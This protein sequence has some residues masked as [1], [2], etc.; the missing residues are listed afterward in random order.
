MRMVDI[1][2][3]TA[4]AELYQKQSQIWITVTYLSTVKKNQEEISC[5]VTFGS[6]NVDATDFNI[7]F[8]GNA[9]RFLQLQLHS[10]LT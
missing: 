10:I 5:A 1:V 7:F 2:M 9:A 6:C 8:I 3:H 4:A